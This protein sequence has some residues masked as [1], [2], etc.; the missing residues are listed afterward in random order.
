[1]LEGAVSMTR[2][3]R[4]VRVRMP[5][6]DAVKERRDEQTEGQEHQPQPRSVPPVPPRHVGLL[7]LR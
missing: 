1:M 7:P 2:L 4:T 3:R 5:V 6:V